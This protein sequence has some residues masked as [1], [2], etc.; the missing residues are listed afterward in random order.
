M[1]IRG[2]LTTLRRLRALT[3]R[4]NVSYDRSIQQ[5]HSPRPH[6]RPRRREA[7]PRRP[8]HSRKSKVAEIQ[9]QIDTLKKE[10]DEEARAREAAEASR[11]ADVYRGRLRDLVTRA[12]VRPEA[13][14][15]YTTWVERRGLSGEDGRL[16]VGP[17]GRIAG[18]R[19]PDQRGVGRQPEHPGRGHGAS[20]EQSRKRSADAGPQ[21]RRRDVERRPGATAGGAGTSSAKSCTRTW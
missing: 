21:A 8:A 14:D 19:R 11:L 12:G 20:A 16:Y 2:T 18:G 13:V 10:R 17:A 7:A 9:Q 3:T 5:P 1:Q 4:F 6:Q 15:M